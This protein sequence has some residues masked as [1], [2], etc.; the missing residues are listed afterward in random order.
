[1]RA[2]LL[3]LALAGTASAAGPRRDLLGDGGRRASTP[4]CASKPAA[5]TRCAGASYGCGTTSHRAS[6]TRLRWSASWSSIKA[7]E[8]GLWTGGRLYNTEDG[9]DYK[10]SLQ[11]RSESTLV[12]SG[13]VLFGYQTQ[14]WRRADRA[15]CPPIA[16]A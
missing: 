15:R 10:G 14:V 3:C 7:T 2:A 6:P 5:A 16:P 8:A 13:C 1:M 9:R 12:V 4:A 11:L